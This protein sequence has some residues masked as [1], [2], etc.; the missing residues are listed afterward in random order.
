MLPDDLT[1]SV[2]AGRRAPD[3]LDDRALHE[4]PAFL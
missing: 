2:M 4:T 1:L 3:Q